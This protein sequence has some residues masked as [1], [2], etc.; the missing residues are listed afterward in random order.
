M[1]SKKDSPELLELTIMPWLTDDLKTINDSKLLLTK[2]E[3]GEVVCSFIEADTDI[4]SDEHSHV[5]SKVEIFNTGDLK[6]MAM[7]LGMDGMSSDWC[8][9]CY[10]RK[11]QWMD[12]GHDEGQPRTIDNIMQWAAKKN[13]KGAARMGVKS[14]PYWDFIP[15]Q[16]YAI[17]LLH[18]MIGV[19]NDIDCYVMDI[20]D[21]CLIAKS[22]Q[23]TAQ[24]EKYNTINTLSMSW[25]R[26]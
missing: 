26:R 21:S 17:P 23:E 25:L 10:L 8:I 19:F 20:I 16:N 1:F 4:E 22:E 3:D 14:N 9:Y 2:V 18:I 13:L 5:I 24:W 6:W 7:L 11:Q 15:V 12:P